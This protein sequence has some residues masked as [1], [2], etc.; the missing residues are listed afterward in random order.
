MTI[1]ASA[2]GSLRNYLKSIQV[3]NSHP[4][5]STEITIN[6]GAGGTVLHRGWAQ[7]AGGGFTAVF[8]PPL[9]G[10]A[11]TLLEVDEITGTATTGVLINAQGY[12]GL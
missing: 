3:I 12:V 9:R 8:D 2:G 5:I 10:T 11:A 6:D 4:T 1:K 7:A